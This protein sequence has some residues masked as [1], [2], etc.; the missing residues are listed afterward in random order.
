M[1]QQRPWIAWADCLAQI[2]A[3]LE[4]GR[5]SLQ[6]IPKFV[7]LAAFLVLAAD[8]AFLYLIYVQRQRSRHAVHLPRIGVRHRHADSLG[9]VPRRRLGTVATCP[10][11][12]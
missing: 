12:P 9:A 10:K 5:L 4:L 8:P 2:Q 3:R 11:P 6:P 1:N 7:L